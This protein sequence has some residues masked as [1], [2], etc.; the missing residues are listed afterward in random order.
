MIERPRTHNREDAEE[1]AGLYL[2]N[3]GLQWSDLQGKKVLDMG[4][5]NAAFEHVA[6]QRGVD[7]VSLD[8]EVAEGGFVPPIDS[9]IVI[10]NATRMPFKNET[11][12]YALAHMSVFNYLEKGY[13]DNE[14]LKYYEDALRETYRVLKPDGQ[15]RFTDLAMEDRNVENEKRIVEELSKRAGYRDIQAI[16][17]PESHPPKKEYR[18]THYYIAIK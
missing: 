18:L 12:D 6:R 17:Y 15:I 13:N 10:A 5:M 11:F 2:A 9:R 14:Y 7:I 1:I 8:N 3:L 16:V 4:A